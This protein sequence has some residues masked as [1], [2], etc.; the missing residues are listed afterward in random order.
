MGKSIAQMEAEAKDAAGKKAKAI[1]DAKNRAIRDLGQLAFEA[2]GRD[3]VARPFD[4][5]VA[6]ARSMIE[7]ATAAPVE[8]VE[9]PAEQP[10]LSL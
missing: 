5:Q 6:R 2:A 1:R 7:A 3:G 9:E 4:E 10:S 8:R